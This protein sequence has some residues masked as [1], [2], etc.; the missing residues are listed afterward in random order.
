MPLSAEIQEGKS[1]LIGITFADYDNLTPYFLKS[2]ENLD[3]DKKMLSLHL[4]VLN[5]SQKVKDAI[6]AWK[7]LNQG[8]YN[9]IDII[10]DSHKLPPNYSTSDYHRLIAHIHDDY[11]AKSKQI[12]SS[13]CLISSSDAFL[14]PH[15]LKYLID[16]EKPVITPMLRPLPIPGDPYRNFFGDVTAYGYYQFHPDYEVISTRQKVGTFKVPCVLKT[17]LIKK[18]YFDRVSFA[19]NYSGYEFITFGNNSRNDQIDQYLCNE[20]EFGFLMH[21]DNSDSKAR[22]EYIFK[23]AD[24]EINPTVLDQIMAPHYVH[25]ESLKQYLQR[26]NYDNYLIFRIENETLFYLDDIFD[27]IKSYFLKNGY[28]WE[29][30]FH[31][32]FDKFIIPGSVALDIGAHIGTH[33]L[34]MSKIVG[35]NGTVYAFEPQNKLFTELA[36]NM[37]LNNIENVKLHHKALGNEHKFIKI[38]IPDEGWNHNR[39]K[40]LVNIINEGHGTVFE[41][42]TD[43]KDKTELVRLDDYNLNNVSFLKMDVEGFEMEVI[44]GAQETILRNKPVMIVEIFDGPETRKRLAYI[45]S[46]GYRYRHLGS[47]DYLFIPMEKNL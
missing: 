10:D 15:T 2:L 7:D 23:G 24:L 20:K 27:Y 21:W 47:R 22:K 13:Y 35:A 30:A 5:S 16:K 11:L 39:S 25:D 31:E 33:T 40:E 45:E 14:A 6:L 9:S 29:T 28:N 44:K 32:H 46:L 1:V 4:N 19:K 26:F 43:E 12:N 38:Q 37:H 17:Y 42:S 18:E 34:A 8:N 3:Y 41:A 36:I